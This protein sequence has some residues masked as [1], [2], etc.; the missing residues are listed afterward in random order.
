MSYTA[1]LLV[2][3]YQHNDADMGLGS[4]AYKYLGN[5]GRWI[6]SF[7]L[8]FLLYSLIAAYLAGGCEIISESVDTLLGLHLASYVGV[9]LFALIGGSVV[10]SGTHSVDLTNRFLFATEFFFLPAMLILLLPHVHSVNL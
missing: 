5:P 8:P 7:A 3:A 10:C 2:E 1:L 6:I 9:L 4:L